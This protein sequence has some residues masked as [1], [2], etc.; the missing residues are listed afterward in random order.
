MGAKRGDSLYLSILITGF[1][2]LCLGTGIFISWY[3]L[4]DDRWI[5]AGFATIAIGLFCFLAATLALASWF[6]QAREKGLLPTRTCWVRVGLALAIL[7]AN[8]PAA[9][10]YLYKGYDILFRYT[11]SVTNHSSQ[12]IDMV[13]VVFVHGST[14]T[15][16]DLGT[17]EPGNS[18]QNHLRFEGE[19]HV[20]YV[21]RFDGEEQ[22]GP[23]F[24]YVTSGLKGI[25][26]TLVLQPDGTI[27]VR[28]EDQ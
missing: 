11:V 24:G 15:E 22:T 26:V 3:W 28:R 4:G 10:W 6:R 18:L 9:A 25:S 20:D 14:P 13:K 16:Y 8:F 23:L 19:G 1:F 2:P 21:L 5:L 12:P 27:Q 7:L 17:V